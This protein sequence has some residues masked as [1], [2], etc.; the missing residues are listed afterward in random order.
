[1]VRMDGK[2]Q[3]KACT[4]CSFL[5]ALAKGAGGVPPK[6]ARSRLYCFSCGDFLCKEHEES[7]HSKEMDDSDGEIGV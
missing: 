5:A 7:F 6:I 3:P 1:M 4:Y 2:G